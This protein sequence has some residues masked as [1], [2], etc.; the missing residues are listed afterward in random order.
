MNKHELAD[1][2]LRGKETPGVEEY[3]GSYLHPHDKPCLACAMGLA[4]VGHCNGDFQQ[5]YKLY[6]PRAR[7]EDDLSVIA[8]LLSIPLSLAIEIEHRHLNGETVEQIAAWLKTPEQ[9]AANV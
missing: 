2:M 6:E 7:T 4:L 1:A 8:D 5:A 3:T 9:E